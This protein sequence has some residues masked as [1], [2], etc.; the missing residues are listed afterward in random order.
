MFQR[1][2]NKKIS[3]ASICGTRSGICACDSNGKVIHFPACRYSNRKLLFR[4]RFELRNA[5]FVTD[6][7]NFD[8]EQHWGGSTLVT[9]TAIVIESIE[10][11][12]HCFYGPG[13]VVLESDN[14]LIDFL[15]NSNKLQASFDGVEFN[16]LS[17]C[18]RKAER[19]IL[20]AHRQSLCALQISGPWWLLSSQRTL[21]R[22]SI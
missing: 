4:L 8:V 22:E 21:M 20:T 14:V 7:V 12:N 13:I 3:K 6:L 10:K 11:V 9:T 15:T 17:S 5:I 19:K 18:G 1:C 16:L 2:A